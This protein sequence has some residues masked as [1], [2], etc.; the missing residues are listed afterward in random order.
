M[1]TFDTFNNKEITSF[2]KDHL[3]K[4][5]SDDESIELNNG[6]VKLPEK[7]KKI[8]RRNIR[9]SRAPIWKVKNAFKRYS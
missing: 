8:I 5:F 7:T 9:S 2:M 1:K 6:I 4:L 3:E